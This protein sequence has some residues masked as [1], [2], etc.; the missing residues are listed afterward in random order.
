MFKE[1]SLRGLPDADFRTSGGGAD[2]SIERETKVVMYR[3]PDSDEHLLAAVYEDGRIVIGE[4]GYAQRT[5]VWPHGEIGVGIG[6]L[7]TGEVYVLN[8]KTSQIRLGD[9]EIE[10]TATPRD[11]ITFNGQNPPVLRVDYDTNSVHALDG[12]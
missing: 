8:D 11:K 4:N 1:G 10:I 12:E 2:L 7:A 6:S 3:Y 9:H 5:V